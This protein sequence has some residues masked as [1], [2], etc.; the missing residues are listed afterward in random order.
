[1]R[2]YF[3]A[4]CLALVF[5]MAATPATAE[6][7][8]NE[9]M[10]RLELSGGPGTSLGSKDRSGDFL[11]KGTV[12]YEIPA[13]PHLSLGLRMIP[14]F[15]YEQKE[16]GEDTV[17]GAGAGLGA[18]LYS[19]ASEYRGVFAE[20]NVHA[21]G[22]KNRFDGNSSNVNFL[23]GVGLGYKFQQGWHTVL[24]YEHISNANLGRHNRGADIITLGLGF[25]F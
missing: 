13:T 25:T 24:K 22:H 19:V 7:L 8:W 10:W 23:T 16:R 9:G 2:P 3:V 15:V 21:L 17:F 18:R 6:I 5:L 20:V 14:L 1:M 12:E 4:L 11:V